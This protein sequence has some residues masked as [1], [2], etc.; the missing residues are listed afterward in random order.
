MSANKYFHLIDFL[1]DMFL[2]NIYLYVMYRVYFVHITL[3][4]SRAKIE[5]IELKKETGSGSDLL[6]IL[7]SQIDKT[8]N[9]Q[10]NKERK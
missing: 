10:E 1:L 9:Q 2:I 4:N 8:K 5:L 7:F 3:F 6:A